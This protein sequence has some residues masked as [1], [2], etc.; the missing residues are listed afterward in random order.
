M[1]ATNIKE[2]ICAANL[3]PHI[4]HLCMNY[5]SMYSGQNLIYLI[6]FVYH[7]IYTVFS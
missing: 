1:T 4:I 3:I 2:N 6:S 5:M 7:I